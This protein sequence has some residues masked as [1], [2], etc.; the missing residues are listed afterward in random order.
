MDRILISS[1]NRTG[2]QK[3]YLFDDGDFPRVINILRWQCDMLPTGYELWTDLI[4]MYGNVED[5]E[6][7][8]GTAIEFRTLN[9]KWAEAWYPEAEIHYLRR[10]FIRVIPLLET[11]T[12]LGSAH[13]N[14]YRLL[15]QAWR[16]LGFTREA[17]RV[18]EK[19]LEAYPNDVRARAQLDRAKAE[20][21]A[22]P[23]P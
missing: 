18:W 15:A 12:S 4:W 9:P 20:L 1:V 14:N 22:P 17:I 11:S 3:D 6:N 5:R 23:K 16:R 19:M 13:E 8:L 7:Q 21:A 10:N 2:M